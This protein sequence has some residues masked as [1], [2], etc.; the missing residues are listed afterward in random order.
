ML[1]FQVRKGFRTR[2]LNPLSVIWLGPTEKGRAFF[3]VRGKIL[4]PGQLQNGHAYGK[5]V[6]SK[7]NQSKAAKEYGTETGNYKQTRRTLC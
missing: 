3:A 4:S 2:V 7:N 1:R 6:E 5:M